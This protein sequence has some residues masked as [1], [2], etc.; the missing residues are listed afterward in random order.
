MHGRPAKSDWDVLDA[1]LQGSALIQEFFLEE[2]D[3][4]WD[5]YAD[6]GPRASFLAG[7]EFLL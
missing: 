5:S 3:T 2:E 1:I 7:W 6:R 4:Q